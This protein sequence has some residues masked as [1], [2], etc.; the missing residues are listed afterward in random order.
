ARG[1]PESE[2]VGR[3]APPPRRLSLWVRVVGVLLAEQVLAV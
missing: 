2:R 1:S 3:A